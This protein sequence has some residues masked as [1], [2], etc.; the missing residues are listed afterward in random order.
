MKLGTPNKINIEYIPSGEVLFCP[1]VYCE[2]A[3]E[4]KDGDPPKTGAWP[5]PDDLDIS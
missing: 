3:G 4:P 1:N 2:G 5:K